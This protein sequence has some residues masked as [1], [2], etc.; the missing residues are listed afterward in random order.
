V[1][2]FLRII[3]LI[4]CVCFVAG[5]GKRT[6]VEAGTRVDGTRR[7]DFVKRNDDALIAE[8][9]ATSLK[10]DAFGTPDISW[11]DEQL[12]A[13]EKAVETTDTS[14]RRAE[15]IMGKDAT[16]AD[17]TW[18]LP[19]LRSIIDANRAR[20]AAVRAEKT[21]VAAKAKRDQLSREVKIQLAELRKAGTPDDSW[22]DERLTAYLTQLDRVDAAVAAYEA[23]AGATREIN[24][25]KARLKKARN[26]AEG[27]ALTAKLAS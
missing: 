5:C 11:T 7:G 4:S 12:A 27:L 16:A 19:R 15:T 20:L 14:T 6:G 3:V 18:S 25:S 26:L 24:S 21:E 13:Y 17:G 10:M 9:R 2:A 23:D 1:T 8:V 22:D